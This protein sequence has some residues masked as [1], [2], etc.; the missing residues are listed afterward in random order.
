M[1]MLK[2]RPGCK[3]ARRNQISSEAENMNPDHIMC[4]LAKPFK[5]QQSVVMSV[6]RTISGIVVCN[7]AG[8]DM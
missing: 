2:P 6:V 4:A 3:I 5:W 8:A 1:Q 7:K